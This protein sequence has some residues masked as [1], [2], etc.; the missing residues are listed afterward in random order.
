ME[1]D[2]WKARMVAKGF[3]QVEG[4]ENEIFATVVKHTSIRVIL[5][6]VAQQDLELEQL[7]VKTAFLHGFIE[8]AI[9]MQQQRDMCRKIDSKDMVC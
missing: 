9:Y 8:K 7:D 2:R 6:I 4:I 1:N 3:T 5:S